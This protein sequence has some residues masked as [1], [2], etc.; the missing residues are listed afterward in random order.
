MRD[1]ILK[2]RDK[3]MEDLQ[4]TYIFGDKYHLEK[5]TWSH[6]VAVYTLVE[7]MYH[8]VDKNKFLATA[9]LHDIGKPF[10]K[11]IL[12]DGRVVYRGHE[13]VSTVLAFEY[14]PDLKRLTNQWLDVIY[15]INYHGVTWQ[16]SKKQLEK[17]FAGNEKILK[18]IFTFRMFDQLGQ[19]NPEN[20]WKQEV[21]FED[22][23]LERT[24]IDDKDKVIHM[25][26]GL[27]NSGK[28]TYIKENF[29]LPVL[30]RDEIVMELG[31]G[32]SYNEAWE[33]VNQNE[34]NKIFDQRKKEFKKYNEFVLDLTNLSWKSRKQWFNYYKDYNFKLYVFLT[35][36]DM[37]I[38][39]N[40]KREGKHIPE[41]VIIDMMKRFELPL[42][43]EGNIAEITFIEVD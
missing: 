5:D 30:S 1:L 40:N 22:L 23:K 16:K 7:A 31:N 28:S 19:I 42:W 8:Q 29:N 2:V 21:N 6:I 24:I 13:N 10:V 36:Y 12:N 32:L 20:I 3:Y 11:T 25:M 33:K 17:Y 15:L 27:P 43:E 35:P 41:K 34:V 9:L 18:D 14:I 26:I 38:D 37:I 4:K 39:R